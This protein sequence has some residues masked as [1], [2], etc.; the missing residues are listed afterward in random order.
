MDFNWIWQA[1]LIVVIGTFLLRIAGRKTI[2]QM[3]LAETVLMIS[4]GTLLIQPVTSKSVWLSFAVG[5]VLVITLLVMEYGQLKSDGLE[6][7]ITGKSKVL[8][9]N[10]TLNEKTMA[11]MRITVDQLEM[12]LRQK[13]VKSISD[14]EWA[15]LEPSGKLGFTLKQHAQPATKK[16]IRQLQDSIN[17][18]LTTQMQ[19]KQLTQSLSDTNMQFD[20]ANIFKEVKDKDHSYT[21]PDHLQ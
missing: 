15:T 21:P 2:S 19:L 3:T 13:N 17:Q 14:I 9:E 11:K 20:Q 4:I 7:M 12:N 10:G 18:L 1:A 16:D 5:A 6:K 8:I